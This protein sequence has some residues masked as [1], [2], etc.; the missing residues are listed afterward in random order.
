MPHY[1]DTAFVKK[2]PL[3]AR[4]LIKRCF[5]EFSIYLIVVCILTFGWLIPR[6]PVLFTDYIYLIFIF[7]SFLLAAY[8][9]YQICYIKKYFY[10]ITDKFLIIRKGVFAP[11]EITVPL[12]RIQ[13]IYV[14]Q[15]IMDRLLNIY[16]V[17]IS[18]ATKTSGLRAHIDGVDRKNAEAL[19]EYILSKIQH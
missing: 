4:K 18:T 7:M 16:D 2:Y 6:S 10:N 14:D 19:R 5:G 12:N 17:H 9:A 15:D 1:I 3:S 13:D 11:K 8:C